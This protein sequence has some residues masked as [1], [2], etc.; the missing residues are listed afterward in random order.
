VHSSVFRILSLLLFALL[1]R[2]AQALPLVSVDV[3]PDAPGVQSTRTL[4]LGSLVSIE[5][6]V[7][8]VEASQPLHAF[9]LDLAFDS[10]IA[11]AI[12]VASG[13]F[14]GSPSVV[15]ESD[16]AA[17]D[18]SFA[19]TRLGTSGVSGAGRI[20]VIGFEAAGLGTTLLSL[21]NVL[22]SAPD[23]VPIP[24]LALADASLT[25]VP[26]PAP[27]L[28]L[29]LTAVLACCFRGLAPLRARASPP[30]LGAVACPVV[31]RE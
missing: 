7:S 18:V 4:T 3:D 31:R 23:G 21:S 1:S 6:L 19:Q 12:S 22:L 8:D 27:A 16:F 2:S 13:G 20:V 24:D 30:L 28:L 10:A 17:P 26:E 5:I 11:L 25:V 9:E 29:L 14:L 15:V